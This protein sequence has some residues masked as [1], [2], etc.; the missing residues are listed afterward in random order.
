MSGRQILARAIR[1]DTDHDESEPRDTAC[2]ETIHARI[3]REPLYWN[4]RRRKRAASPDD[5]CGRR[6]ARGADAPIGASMTLRCESRSLEFVPATQVECAQ[7]VTGAFPKPIEYVK[8]CSIYGA[9]F[10]DIPGTDT[11]IKIGGWVRAEY[12]L[13]ETGNSHATFIAGSGG[14]GNTRI[15]LAPD[16]RFRARTVLLDGRSH[17]RPNTAPCAAY[18]RFGFTQDTTTLSRP[19]C[20]TPSVRSSR[21]P[22]SPLGK[23]QSYFDFVGGSVCYGCGYGGHLAD[24]RGRHGRVRLLGDPRQR[25]DGHDRPRRR[26]G[27]PHRHLGRL[28]RRHQRSRGRL[29][30]GPARHPARWQHRRSDHG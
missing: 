15:E 25:P 12:A 19:A 24:R 29:L 16:L 27:S 4:A 22:G 21:S 1:N 11:C 7:H 8:I 30:P 17:P 9:G 3:D 2:I 14:P 5:R 23:T 28:E 20:S 26:R 6:A 10:F 13:G 18:N